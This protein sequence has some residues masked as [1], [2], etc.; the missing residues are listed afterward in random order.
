MSQPFSLPKLPKINF[1]HPAVLTILGVL[2]LL[3]LFYLFT[4]I[5]TTKLWFDSV[6]Y[7]QVFGT[8]LGTQVLLFAIFFVVMAAGVALNI[9]VATRAEPVIARTPAAASLSEGLQRRKGLT[10]I[11]PALLLGLLSGAA[12]PS[13]ALTYVSW[14][15]RQPFGDADPYFGLDS[16]FYVFEY[17]VWRELVSFGQGVV[18]FGALVALLFY[19]MSGNLMQPSKG[20]WPSLASAPRTHLSVLAGLWLVGFGVQCLLDRFGYLVSEGTLFTGVHF[21]DAN[22]RMGSK[23]ILA[24]IA[25]ICAAL[26]FANLFIKRWILPLTAVVLMV[27]AGL[28]LQLAYP[29]IIQ[30]FEVKPNE[31]D[32]ESTFIAKHIDATRKAFGIDEVEVTEYTAVSTVEPGQL[33]NDA[34]ALPGIR[35]VDPAVVGPTFEQ[36]Q[37]V[38]GYYAFPSTLDVDRYIIDGKETDAVVAAREL[39]QAGIP[40]QNWNNIH[41]V[42]TH[43]YGLAAAYGNRRQAGGLDWI[44]KDLPSVG[45]LGEYEGRI[46]FGEKSTD[47]AIVGREEGQAAIELDT[48]GGGEG[49]GEVTNIY[50]GSGGVPM[51]NFFTR[52]L[53]AVH[54]GDI[55]IMLSDRVNSNSK[56]LYDRTPKQRVQQVAPWLTL[57]Q[58]IY[59]AVVDGR[60]VWIV[61]CY[62]STNYYPNSQSVSLGNAASDSERS[63]DTF[64]DTSVNYLRNSVK[65]VVDATDGTVTLYAWEPDDPILGAYM[66]AFPGIFTA[67]DQISDSLLAHLRYPEDL[68]KVQ[69]QILSR[70]HM[71]TPSLWYQQSDLWEI[72]DD[73]VAEAGGKEPPYYLSIKWP[74]DTTAVFSL[75]AVYVPKNR[76]NLASYFAVV[77]EAA[78]PDYGKLRVLRMSDTQQIDGPGQT[79]N[80][81]NTDTR[82]AEELRPFLNQGSAAASYGNLLTLPMG[83]GLLYVLPVYTQRQGTT[84]SYPALTSVVVRF[85][86]HVGI[87]E[88]LQAALDEVFAG[89]AG[90]DT[91][92]GDSGNGGETP[93]PTPTPVP[94]PTPTVAPTPSASPL[95]TPTGTDTEQATQYLEQAEAAF[96]A[97]DTALRNGDLAT[98]QQQV[99]VARAA[100]GAALE[101]MGR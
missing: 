44:E 92:E 19:A 1:K 78:S 15:N 84:G 47:F 69:R 95:P 97:A 28:I 99:E 31:P 42:Y 75:T 8:L 61:D 22:A 33:K 46:Y 39:N 54:F 72:P 9:W 4:E 41:T 79:F 68:F 93:T 12:A 73:P 66:K 51:G 3:A 86:E 85:G 30:T 43:G 71:T 70:Y 91:G 26:F 87:G 37:Q 16:S 63:A 17:P 77:A 29:M 82:V 62:T 57:D 7:T 25:F 60:L 34:E 59:P 38:R 98:Y 6:G 65:A 56:L 48:P 53:Y 90:A 96:T 2:V 45:E 74:T 27:I 40:E 14:A 11:L 35:L 64:G 23:L 20:R 18:F 49:G 32:K 10:I 24:V 5:W 76:S 88:T 83:S 100:L 89:D 55:N 13:S 52:L 58:N 94:T 101:K 80:A 81:I 21:T 67:K 36:Q 50:A